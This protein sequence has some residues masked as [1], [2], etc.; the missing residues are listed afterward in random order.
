MLEDADKEVE[1]RVKG[2]PDRTLTGRIEKILPAGQDTL[3][4]QA[5][6]YMAGGSMPTR[7][8][9]GPQEDTKAAERFF[10]IRIRPDD[11][12]TSDEGRGTLL[13]GQRVIAR[14][15]MRPKPLLVQWGQSARRLFQRRFHI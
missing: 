7:A 8:E 6:S 1:I 10:E 4:S 11:R 2:R 5:L 9:P 12:A 13:S 3:P 15:S 14:V